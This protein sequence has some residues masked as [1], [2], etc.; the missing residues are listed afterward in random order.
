MSAAV[1]EPVAKKKRKEVSNC[2][3]EKSG[4]VR[5][6]EDETESSERSDKA[7]VVTQTITPQLFHRFWHKSQMSG[8]AAGLAGSL[9]SKQITA[10]LKQFSIIITDFATNTNTETL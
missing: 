5:G 9:S 1:P 7:R 4:E 8:K 10:Q 6:R 3:F 2:H